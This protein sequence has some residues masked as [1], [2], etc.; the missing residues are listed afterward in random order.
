MKEN[1]LIMSIVVGRLN[2][3]H[4]LTAIKYVSNKKNEFV[5]EFYTTDIFPHCIICLQLRSCE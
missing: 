2:S 5:L 1:I 3:A 4:T